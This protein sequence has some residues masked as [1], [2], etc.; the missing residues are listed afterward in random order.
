MS[1]QHHLIHYSKVDQNINHQDNNHIKTTMKVL[2]VL[3]SA[4]ALATQASARFA[5]K[6]AVHSGPNNCYARYDAYDDGLR[7][8][9]LEDSYACYP[10]QANEIVDAWSRVDYD[11]GR[12]WVGIFPHDRLEYTRAGFCTAMDVHWEGNWDSLAHFSFNDDHTFECI[13]FAHEHP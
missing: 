12:G 5:G 11:G 7:G 6:I 8:F 9:R 2:A 13:R 3:A 1:L 4:V 10:S